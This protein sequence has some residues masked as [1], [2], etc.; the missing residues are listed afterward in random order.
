MSTQECLPRSG[1]FCPSAKLSAN[2]ISTIANL[3]LILRNHIKISHLFLLTHSDLFSLSPIHFPWFIHPDP[4]NH[5][6]NNFYLP[7]SRFLPK[8]SPICPLIR[9]SRFLIIPI[10]LVLK[11]HPCFSLTMYS[12]KVLKISLVPLTL[13]NMHHQKMTLLT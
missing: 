12:S 8:L 7:Q 13:S 10:S 3:L 2:W 11:I 4:L 5:P 1:K 6:R 9:V